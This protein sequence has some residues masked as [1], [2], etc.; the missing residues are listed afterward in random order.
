[1]RRGS[2]VKVLSVALVTWILIAPGVLAEPNLAVGQAAFDQCMT[3][4]ASLACE[5]IRAAAIQNDAAL[6]FQAFFKLAI[7]GKMRSD[8][9]V[10]KYLVQYRLTLVK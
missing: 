4:G 6:R 10:N 7:T 5:S 1:M 3:T 9:T 2:N 8:T